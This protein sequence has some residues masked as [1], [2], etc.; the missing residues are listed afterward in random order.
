MNFPANFNSSKN[1]VSQGEY[2]HDR[3]SAK[4]IE[5]DTAIP[6]RQEAREKFAES[7]DLTINRHIET[8]K[9]A[10]YYSNRAMIHIRMENLGLAIEDAN[11][12]IEIDKDYLKAYYRRASANL[13]LAHYDEAV[14]DL[15][16]LQ[17]KIPNDTTLQDK[18][19]KAKTEK[20][21]KRFLETIDSGDRIVEKKSNT[22]KNII[23]Y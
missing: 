19:K 10:I 3:E 23:T 12:A 11:K 1:S 21:K 20:K 2:L 5:V 17:S 9:N 13:L 16:F 15:E 22:L 14:N 6:I 7:E 8:K 4:H 18:L